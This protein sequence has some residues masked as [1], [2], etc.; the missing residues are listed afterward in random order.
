MYKK[1]VQT[2]GE[3]A[4]SNSDRKQ[5]R[6]ALAAR[7][8][9]CDATL[10]ALLPSKAD[11]RVAKVA[12]PSRASIYSVDGV[13]LLVDVSSK[14]DLQPSLYAL[15]RAPELLP[16][17]TLRHADVA[18]FLLGGAD[19]MAPGVAQPLPADLVRGRLYAVF[20]PGMPQAVC[21]G[22]ALLSSAD[23]AAGGG[24]GR[25]LANLHHFGD[26]L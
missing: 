4:V 15:W 16:A 22:E 12:S 24:K 19:L 26:C 6:R 2:S 5:L 7:F 1:P 25:L 10:D 23:V 8:G 11:L 13:P 17:L 21:L 14:G 18:S 3:H 20:A 9:A